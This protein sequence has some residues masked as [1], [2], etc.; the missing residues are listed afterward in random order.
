MINPELISFI[1]KQKET[2][3]SDIVYKQE[4]L[5]RG[6]SEQDIE[7]ALKFISK[8]N[9]G[10]R[11]F[12]AYY[13]SILILINLVFLVPAL[14]Q[15]NKLE[16]MGIPVLINLY[17]VFS[18]LPFAV[19][20]LIWPVKVLKIVFNTIASIVFIPIIFAY[21]FIHVA[22]PILSNQY[23][24]DTTQTISDINGKSFIPLAVHGSDI[25]LPGNV[26][27]RLKWLNE[28]SD[29]NTFGNIFQKEVIEK[30]K[31]VITVLGSNPYT[32]TDIARK[33]NLWGLPENQEFRLIE[34]D[35]K[36]GDQMI[37]KNFILQEGGSFESQ[38]M[39]GYFIRISEQP[40]IEEFAKDYI[41]TP[42]HSLTGEDIKLII[43]LSAK[44]FDSNGTR[45]G[46]YQDIKTI[47]TTYGGKTIVQFFKKD[48]NYYATEIKFQNK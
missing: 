27:I 10:K 17:F 45:I 32:I 30:R 36:I 40:S 44:C 1:Q 22:V 12:W 35:L 39:S 48:S 33:N 43:P 34:G 46:C 8:E 20:L 5:S 47:Q 19:V 18:A 6:W 29:I 9:K 24:K 15:G 2:G 26:V 21:L 13:P 42:E 16:L 23:E 3:V 37:D 4:L 11:N 7:Q 31:E 14:L 28:T 25:L 38:T 41:F